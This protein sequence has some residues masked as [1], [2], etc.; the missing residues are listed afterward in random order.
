MS[1]KIQVM[2][3]DDLD[4]GNA[5]ETVSFALDGVT[6][7]IDLSKRNA[8]ALRAA[9][10]RYIKA[11]RSTRKPGRPASVSLMGPVTKVPARIAVAARAGAGTG[12]RAISGPSRAVGRPVTAGKSKS[13]VAGVN[14][15]AVRQWAK[16][17]GM[18]VS[19]RGRLSAQIITKYLAA[20]R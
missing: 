14:P 7:E 16:S 18:A 13:A 10:S 15:A 12:Q 6:Y 19:E 4:G 2:L 1:R 20:Q 9:M 8:T 11:A 3:H 5:D 17:K